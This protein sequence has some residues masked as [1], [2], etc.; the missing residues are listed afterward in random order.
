MTNILMEIRLCWRVVVSKLI[1]IIYATFGF[2][3]LMSF[4]GR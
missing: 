4:D 1:C 2:A 3:Q